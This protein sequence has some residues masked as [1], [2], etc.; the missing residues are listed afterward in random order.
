MQ[1]LLGRTMTFDTVLALFLLIIIA[2]ML[3]I[4]EFPDIRR[5]KIGRPPLPYFEHKC[6]KIECRSCEI[7]IIRDGAEIFGRNQRTVFEK[8]F[9]GAHYHSV[10]L[11]RTAKVGFGA[12]SRRVR[13]QGNS[14]REFLII[15]IAE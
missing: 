12:L 14:L 11:W 1:H 10:L 9:L 15:R 5:L 2:M 8:T 4:I 13:I 6:H 3:G 7:G